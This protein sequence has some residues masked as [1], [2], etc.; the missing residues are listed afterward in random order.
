MKSNNTTINVETKHK[1]TK[2]HSI[3]LEFTLQYIYKLLYCKR[4]IQMTSNDSI[5]NVET[6]TIE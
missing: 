1:M 3:H 6:K 4:Q 5:K 2:L